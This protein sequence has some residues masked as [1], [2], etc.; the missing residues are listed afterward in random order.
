[1]RTQREARPSL[2]HL[3]AIAWA[4]TAV[5]C[6]D[7]AAEP[8][9]IDEPS[10]SGVQTESASL[11][12]PP[13]GVTDPGPR[14]GSPGAG[15]AF[16]TLCSIEQA[17]FAAG[18]ENFEEIDSVQGT[19]EGQ[20]GSGLG[21]TFNAT[22]CAECH[23]HPAVGGTSPALNPQ[24]E[25]ATRDGAQNIL[26]PFIRADGP[27]RELRLIAVSNANNAPLDGGV[28]GLF[29]IRGRLDAPGCL[30]AQPDF[31]QQI[32]NNNVSFRIPTPTF[33]L[34]LVENTSD[35]T[36]RNNLAANA[37]AKQALGISGHLNTS[38]NDGTVTRFGWKA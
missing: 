13:P 3:F 12:S 4:G 17:I 8:A 34:G 15:A 20:E 19:I 6:T 31:A 24:V 30:L 28:T 26:P 18:Q 9:A 21:P 25:L 38:G 22:G 16:P 5:G 10:A 27:V 36:L 1:M 7:I 32:A 37:S 11:V 23:A 33:G 35:L 2:F 14:A 29:T